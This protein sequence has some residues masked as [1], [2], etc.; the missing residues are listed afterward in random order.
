MLAVL[1]PALFVAVQAVA[2]ES[3]APAAVEAAVEVPPVCSGG[4]FSVVLS[5][6]CL[7][8]LIW[9]AIFVW[10]IALLPLGVLSIV[11]CATLRSRCWPLTTKVLLCGPVFLFV[12]GWLGFVQGLIGLGWTMASASS[13]DIGLLAYNIAQSLFSVSGTLFLIHLYLVVFLISFVIMHFKHKQ[14]DRDS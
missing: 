3:G 4:F 2:Q 14:M 9:A 1:S 13:P 10:A 8:V 7:G 6:G 12:L 11:H 5:S